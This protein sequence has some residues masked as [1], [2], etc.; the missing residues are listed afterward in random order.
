[1]ARKKDSTALF[2]SISRSRDKKVQT[3]METPG[4][5]G[6][7]TQK[8][9]GGA[10]PAIPAATGGQARVTISGNVLL[11]IVVG[12]LAVGAAA[13]YVGRNLNKPADNGAASVRN[14]AGGPG[15]AVN[16]PARTPAPTNK[17]HLVIQ[18][19]NAANA[20]RP[21]AD[22]QTDAKLI[23]A[24]LT[25]NGVPCTV[26]GSYSR[27]GRLTSVCVRSLRSFDYIDKSKSPAASKDLTPE[28]L[29]F[30]K[31]IEELGRKFLKGDSIEYRK[32]KE[33][34]N[35]SQHNGN[36]L[37]PSYQRFMS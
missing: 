27:D 13:Y 5:M 20:R 19:M 7:P 1:M 28:A 24:W 4:W 12:V 2:E 34:Y 31:E 15:A 11:L 8:S 10:P 35:F 33:K 3:G 25:R 22:Q 29:D 16:G 23:V 14:G 26:S 37:D 9:D 21:I 6:Q 18:R 17:W 30:A 32:C 36:K